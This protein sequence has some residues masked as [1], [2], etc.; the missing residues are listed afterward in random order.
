MLRHPNSNSGLY[1]NKCD[2]GM[3]GGGI[4]R[5]KVE[6]RIADAIDFPIASAGLGSSSS[7]TISLLAE[8]EGVLAAHY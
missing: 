2:L 3:D 1:S 5:E 6:R 4:G 8:M 7:M